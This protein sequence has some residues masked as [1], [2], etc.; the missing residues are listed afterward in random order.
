MMSS[1]N[2]VDHLGDEEEADARQF[3][4]PAAEKL[5]QA[6]LV[7]STLVKNG[8]PKRIL[9]DEAERWDADS[10]FLGAKGL[11]AIKRF[12][13]GSVSAGVAA[14]AHCSVEIVRTAHAR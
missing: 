8:D 10:I 3:V 12:L 13:L 14:R 11:R 1:L 9:V 6:G 4:E 2:W 5:R 7:V